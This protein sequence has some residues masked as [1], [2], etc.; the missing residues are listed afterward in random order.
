MNELN[1]LT[2]PEIGKKLDELH[3]EYNKLQAQLHRMGGSANA[4][5]LRETRK[6]IARLKGLES[7]K[8]KAAR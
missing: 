3:L 4:G 5:R 8:S 1:R 2:G 7:Q 6:N